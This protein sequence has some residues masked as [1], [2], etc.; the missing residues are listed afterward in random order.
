MI[1]VQYFNSRWKKFC[2]LTS[3]SKIFWVF[4][5]ECNIFLIDRILSF[6]YIYQI[7]INKSYFP[8]ILIS[9]ESK[10]TDSHG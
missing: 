6:M 5:A 9:S 8:D 3:E 1:D 10:L 7:N 2:Y 4:G